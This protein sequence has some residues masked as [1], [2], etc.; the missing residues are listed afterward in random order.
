M[1]TKGSVETTQALM[2][3]ADVLVAN[4]TRAFL[5]PTAKAALF[6]AVRIMTKL[7]MIPLA[8]ALEP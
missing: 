6:L 1:V 4:E 5:F 3:A 2:E 8:R 7:N